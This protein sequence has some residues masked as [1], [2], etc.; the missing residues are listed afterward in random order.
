MYVD[1]R[2]IREVK[3]RQNPQTQL[4]FPLQ[5]HR[6][7]S[8]SQNAL[9]LQLPEL[10]VAF[11]LTL[12]YATGIGDLGSHAKRVLNRLA[13][14]PKYAAQASRVAGRATHSDVDPTS[15]HGSAEV[16]VPPTSINEYNANI[17]KEDKV[18]F[19]QENSKRTEIQQSRD[20]PKHRWKRAP[21]LATIS[22]FL[23]LIHRVKTASQNPPHRRLTTVLSSR[24]STGHRRDPIIT[25]IF[26][27]E[28][29]RPYHHIT[30]R[31]M[32]IFTTFQVAKGGQAL[33]KFSGAHDEN[34][35]ILVK[36]ANLHVLHS[37]PD[38][39]KRSTV[40]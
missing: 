27:Q 15:A 35:I 8:R 20:T 38:R 24:N 26:Y 2:L 30:K 40:F 6:R 32:P 10:L 31:K 22:I 16:Q 19:K 13:A 1:D 7:G 4:T 28:D 36:N 14:I 17:I 34:L 11:S 39:E 37:T 33:G 23:N 3:H 9:R 25:P 12:P 29:K 21:V 5:L 18:N